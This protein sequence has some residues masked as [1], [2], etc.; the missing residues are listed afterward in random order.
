MGREW[1]WEREE[2]GKTMGQDNGGKTIVGRMM[3]GRMMGGR[4]KGR[5]MVGTQSWRLNRGGRIVGG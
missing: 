2:W 3:G 4:M 1:M 5:R